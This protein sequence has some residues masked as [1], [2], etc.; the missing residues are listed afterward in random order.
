MT[1]IIISSE[2]IIETL[3]VVTILKNKFRNNCSIIIETTPNTR[4][5]VMNEGKVKL[6][7]CVYEIADHLSVT[8]CKKCNKFGHIT[9]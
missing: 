1:Y 8:Q 9:K 3:K 4:K 7:M 6:G 5:I 2:N